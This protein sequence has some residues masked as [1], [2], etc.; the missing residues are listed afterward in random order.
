MEEWKPTWR[1]EWRKI[2]KR[3]VGVVEMPPGL[4]PFWQA[5][6]TM[7]GYAEHC[8]FK[9]CRRG[10]ACA[11]A[12]VL[13]FQA[14]RHELLP[15]F[16]PMFEAKRAGTLTRDT[17]PPDPALIPPPPEWDV[18]YP[19]WVMGGTP[20]VYALVGARPPAA[21]QKAMADA[22]PHGDQKTPVPT[23]QKKAHQPSPCGLR[24]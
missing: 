24:D 9:N 2:R 10:G 6:C 17:P 14:V 19:P 20:E 16:R 4:I 7:Y 5:V 22:R 3:T 23:E 12:D 18:P 21:E 13:C 11:T 1:F 8:P 15:L